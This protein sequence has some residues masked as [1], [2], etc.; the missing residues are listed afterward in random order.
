MSFDMRANLDN[1]DSNVFNIAPRVAPGRDM[2]D[3]RIYTIGK[4]KGRTIDVRLVE[5]ASDAEAL[6]AARELRSDNDL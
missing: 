4:R 2:V 5:A 1:Q 6:A 3:Y